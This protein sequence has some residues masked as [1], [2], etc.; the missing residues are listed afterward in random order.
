MSAGRT[1]ARRGETGAGNEAL[2]R[3]SKNHRF[4]VSGNFS[5]NFSAEKDDFCKFCPK[6]ADF[7]K[8]QGTLQRMVG[9]WVL[10]PCSA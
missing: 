10:S 2:G 1:F 8:N 6:L 9:I 5:A 3:D 4:P 7:P